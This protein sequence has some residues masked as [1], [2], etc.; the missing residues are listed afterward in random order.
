MCCLFANNFSYNVISRIWDL[1]FL[2]GSKILFRI[3][4]AIL[5]V[6][7]PQLMKADG[8]EEIQK[9]FEGI[10]CLIHDARVIIQVSNMPKYKLKNK[11]IDFLRKQFSTE[12]IRQQQCDQRP[13]VRIGQ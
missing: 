1:F 10:Q 5:H 7:K 2:K 4:L 11:E 8:F 12:A 9:C 13:I 6:M 3:S